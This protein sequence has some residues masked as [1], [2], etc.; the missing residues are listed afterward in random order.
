VVEPVA[1]VL[2]ATAVLLARPILPYALAFAAGAMIFV[3]V[4]ELIP[5]SQR[6]G[7]ADLATMGT[8]AGFTATPFPACGQVKS[9]VAAHF[10][11]RAVR[12]CGRAVRHSSGMQARPSAIR[13]T[14]GH[15][16][17]YA[18]APSNSEPRRNECLDG[19]S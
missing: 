4:E 8:L 9:K 13:G 18:R 12:A 1:R 16:S 2:G 3:V 11:H 15:H 17:R 7:H 5:E 6:Y 14:P 19:S 10:D